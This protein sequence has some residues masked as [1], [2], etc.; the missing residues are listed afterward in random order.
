MDR[1]P[2]FFSAW[3][4]VVFGNR[5]VIDA[6]VRA[7]H[8]APSGTL[9]GFLEA[10]RGAHY[11]T[12]RSTGRL[13][14]VRPLGA[15]EPVGWFK[16][17]ALF[18]LTLVCSLAAGAALAG[19]WYP[20]DH[21]GFLAGLGPEIVQFARGFVQGDW[22]T[23]L[24]GWP[25]AVPSVGILLVHELGHYWAARRYA[26]DTTPPIFIP[27]PP[28]AAPLGSPIGSF[29]AYIRVRSPV[30]DRQQLLDV[31][32]AGPLAGFV[33][34][35]AALIWGYLASERVPFEP[36]ETGSYVVFAGNLLWL[37]DSLLTH[38]LREWLVPGDTAVRLSLPAFAGWVGCFLTGLNLLP[39]SQLDGGHIAY[40]LVG[41]RQTNVAV[42]TVIGLLYLTQYS[43]SW[44]L[45]VALA[46]LI[47]GG[48]LGHPPVAIPDRRIPPS[49][50]WVGV[51][52]LAVFVATFVP[53][54]F[55]R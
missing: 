15:S 17:L 9:A 33:V 18:A 27:M 34:A 32:A 51:A 35:V 46:F 40:G 55:A 16:Y 21:P 22:R 11:W 38:W 4:T 48:H 19:V 44:F 5:E 13:V 7:E 49:R 12:D 29:G 23:F 30:L 2:E 25:F 41:R 1:Y 39:L 47:G 6:V 3:R 10:W 20:V 28:L 37:G 42:A 14:L 26:I 8:R 24:V 53:V 36:G 52:C 31:G 43:W 45:W 50:V 54:P